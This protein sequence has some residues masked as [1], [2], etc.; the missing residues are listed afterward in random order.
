MNGC[1]IVDPCI[2]SRWEISQKANSDVD[3]PG[4]ESSN[5]STQ[6]LPLP[7]LVSRHL[8]KV[9]GEQNVGSLHGNVYKYVCN[10]VLT[11]IRPKNLE[12]KLLPK[13]EL[14]LLD[15]TYDWH[16]RVVDIKEAIAFVINIA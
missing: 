11:L 14:N 2:F 5:I 1:N 16:D 15:K 8:H 12:E 13:I 7:R 9:F 3:E 4:C 6:G 10:M